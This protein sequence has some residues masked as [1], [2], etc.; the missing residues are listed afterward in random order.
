MIILP[1]FVR[2]VAVGALSLLLLPVASFA[3]LSS[4]GLGPYY[5]GLTHFWRSPEECI[6]VLALAFLAGLRGPRAGR[7]ALFALPAAWFMGGLAGLALPKADHSTAVVC[8]SFLIL[9]AL[10]AVDANLRPVSVAGLASVFG[11]V[12]GYF[13]GVGMSLAKLGILGL[14]G[15][16]SS[17][18]VLVA[19]AAALVASL[20]VPWTRIVVRVAGSWI[21][22]AG[23]LLIGWAFHTNKHDSRAQSSAIEQ[24]FHSTVPI[25]GHRSS[26]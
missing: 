10:V 4:T 1:R 26:S 23:L 9:G 24:Q 12:F 3:H 20:Q 22:A 2:K 19:L 6:P 13:D 7:Y 11:L 16:V 25:S 17:L 5:D 8:F 14:V 18:F 15:S 21:V